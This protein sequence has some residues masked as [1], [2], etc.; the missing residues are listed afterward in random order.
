MLPK[1][2]KLGVA[3]LNNTNRWLDEFTKFVDLAGVIAAKLKHSNL[4]LP[5]EATQRQR[6]AKQIII[7]AP[8]F[9]RRK[10]RLQNGGNGFF[11]RRFTDAAGHGNHA[12]APLAQNAA[13]IS[14]ATPRGCP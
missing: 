12:R 10:E 9:E 2:L 4:M 3:Y 1:Y 8:A 5:F 6:Q 14:R 13:R 7:I 11:R